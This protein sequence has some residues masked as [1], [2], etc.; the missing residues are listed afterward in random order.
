ML[1][2]ILLL[3]LSFDVRHST[4]DPRV[5]AL[6]QNIGH[7]G[8]RQFDQ[9]EVAAF[10]VRDAN[11]VISSVDWP[12]TG[13]RTSEHYNGAI[14]AG[15]VAI[16]H[17]HPLQADEHPSRGDIAQARKIGLPIYVVTRMNLYVVDPNGDVIKLFAGT[18]WIGRNPVSVPMAAK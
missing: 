18:N 13:N 3:T 4:D 12:H 10:F 9:Q 14:P 17:T 15:T 2:A 8:V 16:V 11:G 7:R 5:L 1:T 6:L